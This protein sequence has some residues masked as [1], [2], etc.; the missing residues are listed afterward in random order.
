MAKTTGIEW[1]TATWNP[2]H[3][4]TKVSPGCAHCY[5]YRD[6]TRYGQNPAAVTRSKTTFFDPL[7]WKEPQA[8]IF[9]CSWSD[10]FIEEADAW[11]PEAWN[12]I[13]N[14]PQHSYLILT[15]SIARL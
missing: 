6:K 14:T 9:T 10:F 1:A 5:M 2:W 12:I 8:R 4:C 11:R 13:Q 7:K 3:G 15:K